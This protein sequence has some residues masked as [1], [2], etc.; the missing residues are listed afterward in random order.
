MKSIGALVLL[1]LVSVGYGCATIVHGTHQDIACSTS[2][3]GATVR[4]ADG[5]K[6]TTP[7][8]VTLT[9]KKD[10]TLTIEKEGYETSTVAIRS[11]LSGAV[12]GNIIAGGLIGWGVDAVSGGQDRLVPETVD[13]TLKPLVAKSEPNPPG[14]QP[15]SV[16][17]R[18]KELGDLQK[19]NVISASEF[20]RMK[21]SLLR[22]Y[23]IAPEQEL[24]KDES[25]Q[26]QEQPSTP[27]GGQ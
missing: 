12:A 4:S 5:F 3:S 22:E 21:E 2:P 14:S 11:V 16:L 13:V 1:C 17:E 18:L 9:R 6:C 25:Q 19:A 10:N 7:C 27:E 20:T 23:G 15:K 8:T 26:K 24:P